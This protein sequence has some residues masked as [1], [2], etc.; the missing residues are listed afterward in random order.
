MAH[1][2]SLT[3]TCLIRVERVYRWFNGEGVNAGLLDTVVLGV[4]FDD[5]LLL[6]SVANDS[7]PKVR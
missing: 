1:V 3:F 7:I 4:L 2:I 6:W 5:I